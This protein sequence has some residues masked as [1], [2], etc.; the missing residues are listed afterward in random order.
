MDAG[1]GPVTRR[2]TGGRSMCLEVDSQRASVPLNARETHAQCLG[3]ECRWKATCMITHALVEITT[4]AG[5]PKRSIYDN[6][7]VA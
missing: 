3:Q 1:C 6:H 2:A 5:D 7:V 4:S